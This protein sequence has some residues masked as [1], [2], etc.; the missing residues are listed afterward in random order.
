M[1]QRAALNSVYQIQR[2]L[3]TLYYTKFNTA[4]QCLI[5]AVIKHGST[6]PKCCASVRVFQCLTCRMNMQIRLPSL[7]GLSSATC[8]NRSRKYRVSTV[9]IEASHLPRVCLMF[10][11]QYRREGY[12][13]AILKHFEDR[14]KSFDLHR[15]AACKTFPEDSWTAKVHTHFGDG[16]GWGHGGERSSGLADQHGG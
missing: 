4:R 9:H 5:T 6:A 7:P 13:R 10:A 2:R 16:G 12:C 8:S 1:A 14:A 15:L 3:L 11:L